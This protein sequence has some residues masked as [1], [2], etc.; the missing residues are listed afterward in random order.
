[1]PWTGRVWP[2]L[3]AVA[4]APPAVEEE[5]E[6]WNGRERTR[7][8]M[9]V[10]RTFSLDRPTRQAG[11]RSGGWARDGTE[12]ALQLGESVMHC[13]GVVALLP[14]LILASCSRTGESM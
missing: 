3:A 2:C 8:G 13:I 1:V 7:M 12:P 4:D 14:S 9:P 6:G 11:N 5:R 10:T